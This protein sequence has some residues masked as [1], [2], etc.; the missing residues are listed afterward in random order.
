M[1]NPLSDKFR[2]CHWIRSLE[3]F[4]FDVQFSGAMITANGRLFYEKIYNA[5][6]L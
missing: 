1:R 3:C 2:F 6:I 4:V 5:Y